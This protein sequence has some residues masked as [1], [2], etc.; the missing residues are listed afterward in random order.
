[1][2]P[3]FASSCRL[4]SRRL[5]LVPPSAGQPAVRHAALGA[6]TALPAQLRSRAPYP[7]RA[8]NSAPAAAGR[9]RGPCL[10]AGRR[11]DTCSLAVPRSSEVIV[12]TAPLTDKA[13]LTDTATLDDTTTL[14]DTTTLDDTSTA[15]AGE[16]AE[17]ADRELLIL[18]R[19][20]PVPSQRRSAACEV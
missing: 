2:S 7:Q 5:P 13:T 20:L 17:W 8:D 12:T 11:A 10:F 3:P 4:R 9:A 19:S 16:L 6:A 14:G 18:V 1:M 15:P